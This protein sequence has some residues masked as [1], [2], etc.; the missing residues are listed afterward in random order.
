MELVTVPPF[1]RIGRAG[2]VC[3]ALLLSPANTIQSVESKAQIL[4]VVKS[5][6]FQLDLS[7]LPLFQVFQVAQ[8]ILL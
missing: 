2:N 6:L 7:L 8:H 4:H 3:V 5:E 1:L